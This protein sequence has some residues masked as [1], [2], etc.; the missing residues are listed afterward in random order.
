M[1]EASTIIPLLN[2][3][4]QGMTGLAHGVILIPE[5]AQ[6]STREL[7]LH[8]LRQEARQVQKPAQSKGSAQVDDGEARNHSSADTHPRER[9]KSEKA[10]EAPVSASPLVGNLLN[11]KV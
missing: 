7:A 1:V 2:A 9:K 11:V 8:L 10:S 4:Q 6:A 3:Q 5:L